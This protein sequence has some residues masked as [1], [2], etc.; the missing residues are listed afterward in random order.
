M[1]EFSDVIVHRDTPMKGV[2]ELAFGYEGDGDSPLILYMTTK[3]FEKML[4]REAK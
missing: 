1:T 3:G 4:V 2:V